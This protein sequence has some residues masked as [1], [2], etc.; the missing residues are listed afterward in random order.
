MPSENLSITKFYALWNLRY[1]WSKV[2]SEDIPIRGI[3]GSELEPITLDTQEMLEKNYIVSMTNELS[4]PARQ[5]NGLA[6]QMNIDS[7]VANM[8]DAR[9]GVLFASEGE[10][11]VP[12][13]FLERR[14]VPITP[15]VCF[16][17]EHES[18]VLSGQDVARI[19]SLAIEFSSEYIFAKDL[20]VVRDKLASLGIAI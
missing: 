14:I 12:D 6:M 9:W 7:F 2:S 11:I 17:A 10:F 16:V 3:K 4:F 5:I 1:H 8:L 15:K 19:N 13:N 18:G 20:G